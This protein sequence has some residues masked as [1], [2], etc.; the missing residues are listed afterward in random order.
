MLVSTSPK[1]EFDPVL[2]TSELGM[3]TSVDTVVVAPVGTSYPARPG[4][5]VTRPGGVSP[6]AKVMCLVGWRVGKC[7]P[8]VVVVGA[9]GALGAVAAATAAGS[10]PAMSNA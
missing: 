6:G 3:V 5:C 10:A 9:A 4:V 2:Q 8:P 1:F 7:R